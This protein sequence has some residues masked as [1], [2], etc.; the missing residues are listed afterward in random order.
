MSTAIFDTSIQ[1]GQAWLRAFGE[2]GGTSNER[3]ATAALRVTLHV[4][5]DS[6]TVPQAIELGDCL[7]VLIR[8]LYYEGWHWKNGLDTKSTPDEA[9]AH[10]R[11]DMRGH[12]EF[13][14]E[15]ETVRQGFNALRHLLPQQEVQSLLAALPPGIQ[16]LWQRAET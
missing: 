6:L 5:R 14:S 7:P 2:E 9:M 13:P 12:E 1:Q 3:S 11:H 8:G 16:R 15:E 4:L 10:A